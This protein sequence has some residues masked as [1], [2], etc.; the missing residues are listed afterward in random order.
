MIRLLIP[1]ILIFSQPGHD[2]AD[3]TDHAVQQHENQ[4]IEHVTNQADA[5][6]ESDGAGH[7]ESDAPPEL[8]NVIELLNHKFGTDFTEFLFEWR[9]VIFS[10]LVWLSLGLISFIVFRKRSLVPGSLQNF[11][12]WV[13][14]GLSSMVVS[15]LGEGGRKYVPFVG[16]LFIYIFCM[17][18]LGLIPGLFSST[19]KLN[20]TLALAIC[21][22]LYV[23]FTGIRNFGLFGYI[24]HLAG[25]PKSVVEWCLVPLN[26]PLHIIG[27]LAK[28]L[29]L[30]LRLFGNIAGEDMLLA[31][32]VILGVSIMSFMHLPI[33]LPLHLPFIFLA[34]LTSFVQALVF[35]L[36]ATIYFSLMSHHDE[37]GH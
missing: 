25:S 34:L 12:E 22:F 17:N 19:S 2:A 29:S 32:F 6:D 1:L 15:I 9:L 21:V 18:I 30:S 16:T 20:T 35:S 5:H 14:E 11:L 36:L 31:I 28:P 10:A 24:Y 33:G 26:L 37:E 23:Q 3:T 13:V 27:E 4:A 8:P 7:A